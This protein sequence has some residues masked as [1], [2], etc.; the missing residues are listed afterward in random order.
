MSDVNISIVIPTYQEVE[1]IPLIAEEINS[2]LV[3]ESFEVIYVDDDSQDGSFDA[4][5]KL[6]HEIPARII[7]RTEERGLSTAVIRGIEEAVG[8]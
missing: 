3:G 4:V 8:K 5:T 6:A 1:N 7:V 2:A